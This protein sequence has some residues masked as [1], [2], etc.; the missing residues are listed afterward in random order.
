MKD[1]NQEDELLKQLFAEGEIKPH[2]ALTEKVMHRIGPDASAFQYKPVISKKAWIIMGSSFSMIMIFLLANSS[3]L[4]L[5]IPS[6]LPVLKD[7]LYSLGNSF[8]FDMS[9]PSMP[10]ISPTIL[11]AI[12][13]INLIGIYLIA[14][15]RWGKWMFR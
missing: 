8:S 14:I 1:I 7:G 2:A 4:Q 11:I 15:Y 5:E 3:G 9:L 12:A 13:A 10:Q 6:L